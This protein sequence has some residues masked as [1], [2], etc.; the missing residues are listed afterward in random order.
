MKRIFRLCIFFG[1]LTV[2]L[3]NRSLYAKR[4]MEKLDRG[5]VAVRLT[6]GDVF[7]SW[8]MLGTD[9][10]TIGFNV[11]GDSARLNSATITNS[12]NYVDG[13]GES[14]TYFVRPVIKGQEREGSAAVTVWEQNYHDI[15]IQKPPNGRT[16]KGEIYNYSANDCSV[17]DVD[18]DGEYEIFLKWDPS[19]AQ[20]NSNDGYTGNVFIDAY[21]QDGT[22]L[23]RIDLGVNIRAGAHYTQFMVYDLDSDGKTEMAC[24]TADGTIDGVGK[25]IGDADADF[26]SSVGRILVGPEYMTIFD[27][28]TGEALVTTDYVPQRG[29]INDWGDNYGNRS[30]R[31]L[32]CIAYLDGVEPSLV[33]CRGYYLGRDGRTGRTV[34]SAW[35]WRKGKLTSRWV[36]NAGPTIN[37]SYLGQGN[38][39][40]SV[41]D[42]DQDGFDEIVYGAC[43]IDH[44]G[45]GL[46]STGLGHGDALH[47][48][49]FNPERP[50]LEVWGIHEGDNNP[51]GALLAAESGDILWITG[52]NDAGRGVA[53]DLNPHFLGAECWGGTVGLR[54]ITNESAGNTPSSANHVIWWDGDVLRELLDGTSITK[55]S[56]LNLLR[57]TGCNSNNG[58]KSN[59]CLQVD[60]FGDWRE[61]VIFRT[62]AN[63]HL[64]IFTTTI[65]TSQRFYT[66]M[67]DPQY[68]LSVAWQNVAYNQPPHT[69]FYMGDNMSTPPVP[70]IQY[71]D[72]SHV[73]FSP[74]DDG[75]QIPDKILLEQNY[76]NPFNQNTE[77]IFSLP[78]QAHTTLKLYNSTGQLVAT[79]VDQNKNKGLH[80]VIFNGHELPSGV[81]FYEL[82]S[83]ESSRMKKMLLMK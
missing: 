50:G 34:L 62:A 11:Y 8:R 73:P 66:L 78:K 6:N 22:F 7:V 64:R 60:L 43:C 79:L 44:D 61:E 26:R 71:Y 83:N 25:V 4:Y 59:P 65:T 47:L 69:G 27:G 32:A 16:P 5:V 36:F 42:V 81:Y 29:N 57:A 80:N 52:N 67:H 54:S 53:A 63:D 74:D 75:Q 49:D 30:D 13:K 72:G 20:D 14:G 39:N 40:L 2:I 3:F 77:I 18:G 51:G 10:S 45:T 55:Y 31:F 41:G 76:P 23:W 37:Y 19:N 58:T 12:T 1:I 56:G 70:D 82:R 28:K 48:S 46:W 38:H 33:M 17:G 68:R 15:P 35:D 21:K 24:K 9:P